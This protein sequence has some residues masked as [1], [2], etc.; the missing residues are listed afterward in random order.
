[1]RV[2]SVVA[3]GV[4]ALALVV[5][6]APGP[7]SA[8]DGDISAW[9]TQ[10][11]EDE[12]HV[13]ICLNAVDALPATVEFGY[14]VATGG[15]LVASGRL[16]DDD[17]SAVVLLAR[18]CPRPLT[19][20]AVVGLTPGTSYS[21]AVQATLTPRLLLEADD[22]ADAIPVDP[23][24]PARQDEASLTVTTAG[25]P[26]APGAPSISPPA[27]PGTGQEGESEDVGVDD[28]STNDPDP[29][30]SRPDVVVVAADPTALD[31]ATF[32][33]LTP[34]QVA[35]IP[36]D[37]FGSLSPATLR[38]VTPRQALRITARQ[39]ATLTPVRAASLRPLV[40]RS[41]TPSALR[42]LRP[43]AMARLSPASVDRLT[44]A[45][46]RALTV[47]QVSALR[48]RQLAVLTAA[49]RSLLRR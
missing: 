46:L 30:T 34:E 16:G 1:M 26:P 48:P 40:V 2:L 25:S 42:A 45:Q 18:P 47:R 37:V 9:V 12:V 38:A 10:A 17:P 19:S 24:R 41:M 27:D 7:A 8:D 5:V 31:P 39:A 15:R 49:E 4:A 11:Y 32:A 29:A 23:D 43:A 6:P 35:A 14:T 13:A 20:F 36:P 33:T 3:S 28:P 44:R 21:V 22:P